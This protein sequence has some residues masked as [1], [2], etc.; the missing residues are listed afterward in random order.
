M[1]L[2]TI[3][4]TRLVLI[5]FAALSFAVTLYYSARI[6][7]SFG[8]GL[9]TT[10]AINTTPL[11]VR[12]P[13]E[14]VDPY[15]IPGYMYT[16]EDRE[17]TRWIPFYPSFFDLPALPE[18]AYPH[19]EDMGDIL[20]NNRTVDDVILNTAPVPWFRMLRSYYA[21]LKKVADAKEGH[22]PEPEL[23][24]QDEFVR[25]HMS[26]TKNR[27]ILLMGDSIDRN[28]LQY[29]CEDMG[30]PFVEDGGPYVMEQTTAY[31]HI[32][33]INITFVQWHIAGMYTFRPEWWWMP[34]K[35][36][37][38]EDRFKEIFKPVSM[39]RV[40]GPSG[41]GP[42]LIL[43]QSGTWDQVAFLS[44][45]HFH[46]M[47]ALPEK[48]RT[49]FV[50]GRPRQP[51]TMDQLRF[52]SK[53]FIKFVEFMKDVFGDN[54]PMMYRSSSVRKEGKDEDAGILSIDRM[55]R[56][57]VTTR[58]NMEIFDWSRLAYGATSEYRDFIHFNK[59]RM[60]WLFSDMLLHYL[61]RASGG[62]EIEGV[63]KIWPQEKTM[64][65]L[66]ANWEVCHDYIVDTTNR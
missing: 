7:C 20:L 32:P 38:F 51:L 57:L 56:S 44:G 53:R 26:W 35:L 21:Y 2:H 36:V 24:E 25:V 46:Q 29:M 49:K 42:D 47:Q 60:S 34:M 58:F 33:L 8:A 15:K 40:I 5:V 55:L 50:I 17:E 66:N 63:V 22:Q 65:D 39:H 10:N 6:Y 13:R 62:V 27:R 54:V 43:M 18:T 31:C 41:S 52:V 64:H 4:Q 61:F 48:N 28:Q 30:H 1:L 37:S 9:W 14:C 11:T 23:S 16:T 59:G 3:R 12:T 45:A 19:P